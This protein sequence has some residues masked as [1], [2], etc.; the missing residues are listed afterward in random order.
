VDDSY[1]YLGCGPGGVAAVR[2]NDGQG[3]WCVPLNSSA[4]NK[5]T[6]SAAL[7]VIPGVLFVAGSDGG[8]R[9]LSTDDGRALWAFETARPFETVNRVPARGG[10]IVSAGPTVAGGML[11]VG[12]GYGVIAESPGNVLLAFEVQ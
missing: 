2:L 11:F 6:Y 4:D 1:V 9:A 10:S 8:L 12:S 7:T 3:K 5:V